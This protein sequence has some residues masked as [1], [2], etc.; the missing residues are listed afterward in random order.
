MELADAYAESR[1]DWNRL[2]ALPQGWLAFGAGISGVKFSWSF[3]QGPEFAAELYIDTKDRERNEE[4]YRMLEQERSELDEELGDVI[5]QPLPE[6]R[7]CRIKQRTMT[8]GPV[9]ELSGNERRE[10]VEW[11]VSTMNELRQA[12]EPQL[13]CV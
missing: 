12:F 10:L 3:H 1:P 7:A 11:D 4:I 5:W 2:K 8:S 6:K 13:R 9:E